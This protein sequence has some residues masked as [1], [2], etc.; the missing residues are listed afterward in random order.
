MFRIFTDVFLYFFEN[1]VG[2]HT[3]QATTCAH[4][5][6]QNLQ[7][8]KYEYDNNDVHI[9]QHIETQLQSWRHT[10]VSKYVLSVGLNEVKYWRTVT[11]SV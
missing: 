5:V 7:K 1:I 11:K 4:C 10:N 2:L 9:T 3:T 6:V 8:F